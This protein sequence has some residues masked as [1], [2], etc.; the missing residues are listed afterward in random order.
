MK[1]TLILLFAL[2]LALSL[3]LSLASCD[4]GVET[5]TLNVYNWGQYISDGSEDSFDTNKEFEAYWNAHLAE[6]Y[7]YKIEVNYSTYASNEDMYNKISSGSASYDVIIPSDYMI[8]QMI[9][10]DMLLP[11]DFSKIPNY[12]YI[13]EE[14]KTTYNT[15]D[16]T[17]A[18]SVPYTYGTVGIIYNTDY[19][20]EEDIGSWDILWNEKYSGKILQFNN[21]R[22]AM[23]TALYR[24]GY[25]VNTTD[26]AKWEAAAK[27]LIEQKPLVQAYVMDEIFNKMISSSSWI[28]PYYAGDFLTCYDSNDSLAFFTPKEGTNFFVDAMCI[29]SCAKNIDAAHAYIDFMLTE[30]AAV[31]NAMYIGYSSPHT[32]VQTSEEYIEYMEDWHEDAMSILYS[33]DMVMSTYEDLGA[34]ETDAL[35]VSTYR[36]ITNTK[37]NG[38]LLDYTNTLWSSIKVESTIEPWI[39]VLDIV[40]IASLFSFWLFIFL[41]NR[42]RKKDY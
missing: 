9:S 16:P 4:D 37:E 6:R 31:A 29:P 14:F 1:K 7:G 23:A 18:Y 30:E 32:L 24:L 20:D 38:N 11:L 35:K 5:R 28:A 42:S 26:H 12:A 2:A 25:S 3:P 39:I 19:V 15:Y 21:L 10:Q 36:A 27:L 41:R 22:D 13:A 33:E 40:I 34:I 8:E 17:G